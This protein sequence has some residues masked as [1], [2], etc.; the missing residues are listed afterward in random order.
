MSKAIRQAEF[1][2]AYAK[3]EAGLGDKPQC[4]L[5]K[6]VGRDGAVRVYINSSA[7]EQGVK[8]WLDPQ[9]MIEGAWAIRC[10]VE[11]R[12]SPNRCIDLGYDLLRNTFGEEFATNATWN[13]ILEK[14]A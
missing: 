14:C 10:K 13:Q 12:T 6:W 9:G 8:L 7:V 1:R 3:A 4:R 2:A 5:G 11:W